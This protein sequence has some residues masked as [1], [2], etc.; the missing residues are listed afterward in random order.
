M[1]KN[2]HI[3]I[4]KLVVDFIKRFNFVSLNENVPIRCHYLLIILIFFIQL[5]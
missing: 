5:N 1:Y 4:I 2:E 3:E